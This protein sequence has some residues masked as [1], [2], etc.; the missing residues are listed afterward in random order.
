MKQRIE[1][2]RLTLRDFRESD[3]PALLDFLKA[4]R[5]NCFISDRLDTYD[6]AMKYI[7]KQKEDDFNLAICLKD[8]DELIGYIY[9]QQEDKDTYSPAW[10]I[11][12]KYEGM[13]YAFEATKAYMDY[14]FNR[15][16]ARRIYVYVE[17][18]NLRSK[19]LCERL[20]MRYEGCFKEFISFVNTPDGTPRYEDTCIYAILKKEWNQT[21]S[22]QWNE[23]YY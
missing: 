1:T 22:K 7:E 10:H 2:N 8:T 9:N 3:A 14:L 11:N 6:D 19:R 23:K 12:R 16:N 20:G 5:V 17:N 18:D 15:L 13:G 4:P 21:T